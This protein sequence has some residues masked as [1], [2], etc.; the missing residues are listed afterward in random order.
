MGYVLRL[1]RVRAQ[2]SQNRIPEGFLEGLLSRLL[3]L[4]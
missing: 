1:S 3:P 4:I 2:N